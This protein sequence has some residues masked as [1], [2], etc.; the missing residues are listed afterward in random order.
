LEKPRENPK[1]ALAPKAP[2]SR[3]PRVFAK[4]ALLPERRL[5]KKPEKSPKAALLCVPW[6][7][8]R[9]WRE[10]NRKR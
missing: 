9:L 3:F 6:K 2:P 4:A 7:K 5:C 1:A 10:W 8:R